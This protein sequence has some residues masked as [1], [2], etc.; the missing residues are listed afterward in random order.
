MA[1]VCGQRLPGPW[2]VIPLRDVR[3]RM[4]FTAIVLSDFMNPKSMTQTL[5]PQFVYFD[6]GNVVLNFSHR[7]AAQQMAEVVGLDVELVWRLVFENDLQRRLE[8]GALTSQEFC[9]A[10]SAATGRRFDCDD[11]IRAGSD[12]FWLNKSIVPLISN[13]AST[14]QPMGLLSN[15]CEAHWQ[16]VCTKFPIVQALF[17]PAILSFEVGAMKPEPAV[18][19]AAITAARVPPNR[20]FFVDDRLD[21]VQGAVLAGMDAHPYE[22]AAK[23]AD[24]LQNR[25]I[26]FNY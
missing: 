5:P 4:R 12:I 14:G 13:L 8:M 15:T 1:I 23:L 22:S 24:L 19:R 16:L 7:R 9:A 2:P 6:L 26:R 25:G 11:L 20:I 18:Y 3:T 10:L 17:R 21:N